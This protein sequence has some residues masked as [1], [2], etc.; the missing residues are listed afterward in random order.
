MNGRGASPS[1]TVALAGRD[2]PRV[3]LGTSKLGSVLPDALTSTASREKLFRYLDGMR[4]AGCHALDLAASYQLGGTER[5]IGNW[6]QSRKNRQGLFLISKGGH[7]YP[8]VQPHRLTAGAIRDDLH[9]SLRRLRVEH[10]DLYLLHRDD[11][12]A[13]L[14]PA[15]EELVTQ[16]GQGTIGAWGVSNWTHS[17]IGTLD[18]MARSAG[19]KVAASSPQFSLAEWTTPPFLGVVSMAGERNR[20]ARAFHEK[21]QIPVLAWSPLGHGFFATADGAEMKGTLLRTY[22]S[23]ANFDRKRRAEVLA[24]RHGA[25]VVQIAL[26]YLFSQPFPV[27]AA[28]ATGTPE[29]MRSNLEATRL[30]LPAA[31][32]RWLESGEETSPAPEITIREN[33]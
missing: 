22:G 29:R 13:S 15:V 8:L 24:K 11:P 9:A 27:L 4:E 5:L 19:S 20:E 1:E 21:S 32:L 7:P 3:I 25:T 12:T 18:A 30:R 33:A 26:S 10:I 2:V 17:R 31:E 28:V 14:E 6:M 16:E 23:E